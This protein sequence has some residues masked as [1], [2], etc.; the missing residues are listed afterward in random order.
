M[1]PYLIGIAGPSCAGKGA[2]AAWLSGRLQA[3]VLDLDS[4]YREQRHIPFEER[5]LLNY[6]V[7]RAL[8]KDLLLLQVREIA[9]GR[10][11]QKPVYDF[12]RHTR[13]DSVVEFVPAGFVIID[14]LFTLYW[15]ELRES[16]S[17]KVFVDTPDEECLRRRVSRDTTE[18]GRDVD[19]VIRQFTNQVLPAAREYVRPTRA[20]A[21]L[22]LDGCAPWEV[23]GAL[24]LE[25][26]HSLT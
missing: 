5:R 16:M 18:R 2:L 1:R 20:F 21:D 6:D 9:A 15:P 7:P 12:V 23:N 19:D 14:G 3:S 13:A 17:L 24:V 4:Y 22:V 11:V 8:D 25:R 10:T 26:I